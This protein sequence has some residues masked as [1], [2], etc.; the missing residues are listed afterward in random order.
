MYEIMNSSGSS[1]FA[2]IS[3]WSMLK[4]FGRLIKQ[5]NETSIDY[6]YGPDNQL[7]NFAFLPATLPHLIHETGQIG[8]V[9]LFRITASV[10]V[11]N[12]QLKNTLLSACIFKRW[13]LWWLWSGGG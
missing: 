6:N 7:I 8:L 3:S 4:C 9:N 12:V 2:L 5:I 1:G 10:H 11:L 13:C